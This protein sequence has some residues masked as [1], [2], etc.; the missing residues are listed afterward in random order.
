MGLAGFGRA[1]M[2]CKGLWACVL[3]ACVGFFFKLST[4]DDATGCA[5]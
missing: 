2:G 1:A 3:H 4:C 5:Q